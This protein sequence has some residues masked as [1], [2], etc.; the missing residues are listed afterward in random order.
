MT[1]MVL[2]LL[3]CAILLVGIGM[4]L[5]QNAQTNVRQ[6]AAMDFINQQIHSSLQA[7]STHVDALGEKKPR[8]TKRRSFR[9]CRQFAL[10]AGIHSSKSFYVRL[11][12]PAIV[13]CLLAAI[14]GGI[15]SVLATLLLYSALVIFRFW[16][17]MTRRHQ[18]MVHQLPIFLDSMV[19]LTTIGNSLESAFQSTVLTMDAPLS[20]LLG[21]ANYL[22]KASMDLEHALVQEARIFRL[23]EMQLIGAVIG[24]ALRFGGRADTV[25]ER[26][27]DFMRDREQAHNELLA[28]SAEIRLS[29]WILALLPIGIGVFMIIFNN[30]IFMMM[31]RDSVGKP[32]LLGAAALEVIGGYLLYRMAKSV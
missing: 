28:L 12:V 5:W 30:E 8:R 23:P 32:M 29:A 21:R 2:G 4:L 25:L 15:L 26:M 1:P 27:A 13:L 17:K 16:L 31:L 10:R 9:W 22:V 3:A 19:R 24:I 7:Q 18:K 20:E 6:H 14:F 11:F